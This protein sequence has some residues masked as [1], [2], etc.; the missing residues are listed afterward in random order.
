M[1]E[2]VKRSDR[3]EVIAERIDTYIALHLHLQEA[4]AIMI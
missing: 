2:Q 1:A 4:G 3:G